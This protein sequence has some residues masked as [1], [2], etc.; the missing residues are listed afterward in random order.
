MKKGFVKSQKKKKRRAVIT[1]VTLH[2]IS[3]LPSHYWQPPAT[4]PP[5]TITWKY[6]EA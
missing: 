1:F 4:T 2:P 6:E 3:S 5:A